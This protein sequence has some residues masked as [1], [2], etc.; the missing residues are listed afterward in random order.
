MASGTERRATEL[1][2]KDLSNIGWAFAIAGTPDEKLF[3][4]LAMATEQQV[5]DFEV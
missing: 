4:V 2:A 5:S 3:A 1:N